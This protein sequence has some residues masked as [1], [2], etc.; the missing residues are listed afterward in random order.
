M[1]EMI[2]WYS[3]NH[4]QVKHQFT[5]G[6]SNHA[7]A[8]PG[9]AWRHGFGDVTLW[10]MGS[11][12]SRNLTVQWWD[13]SNMIQHSSHMSLFRT[14]YDCMIGKAVEWMMRTSTR[15]WNYWHKFLNLNTVDFDILL[16]LNF[17]V[18]GYQRQQSKVFFFEVFSHLVASNY[19]PLFHYCMVSPFLWVTVSVYIYINRT[20]LLAIHC[21]FKEK[22]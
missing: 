3:L 18:G 8:T 21:V 17:G 6:W 19:L 9:L 22:G 5:L 1:Q 10:R 7:V 16:D 4:P 20:D 11:G 13:R 15:C 14:L 2:T 12:G